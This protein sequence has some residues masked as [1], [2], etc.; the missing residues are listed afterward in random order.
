MG[1]EEVRL[2][3][4]SMMMISQ[5]F[6]ISDIAL[7]YYIIHDKYTLFKYINNKQHRYRQSMQAIS[8]NFKYKLAS[9]HCLMTVHIHNNYKIELYTF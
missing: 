3:E 4:D 9:D 5:F 1:V 8:Q 2:R 7:I 6:I